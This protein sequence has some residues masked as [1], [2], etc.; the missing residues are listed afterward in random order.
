MLPRWT[1]S[2]WKKLQEMLKQRDAAN[3]IPPTVT[4]LNQLEKTAKV[5]AS[6]ADAGS[7][8][9]PKT[10]AAKPLD[11][12]QAINQQLN[13]E[14]KLPAL[15]KKDVVD[16]QTF[17]RRVY[18][19]LVGHS[20][21]PEELTEFVF[22]YFT[23]KRTKVVEKLLAQPDYGTNWARYW[24]D[25]IMYRKTEDRALIA[26]RPAQ[27]FLTEQLNKNVG[28]DKITQQFITASGEI[29]EKRSDGDLHGT[30]GRYRRHLPRKCH[31]SSWV[32]NCNV[33][34]A[35]TIRPIVGNASSFMNSQRSFH[36]ILFDQARWVIFRDL[37]WSR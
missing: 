15:S 11:A 33:L 25:V 6:K 8:P 23:D 34:S 18:L 35:T 26:A 29:V 27:E 37:L 17:L 22:G 1:K 2:A 9:L 13:A 16:D 31:A 4:R 10:N 21:S 12:A 14:L 36:A 5:V 28:W 24:R 30:D 19:D 32:F 3:S 7:K 20:P